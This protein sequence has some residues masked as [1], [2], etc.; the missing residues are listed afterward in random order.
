[1][2]INNFR[3]CLSQALT[4]SAGR[5]SAG[6]RVSAQPQAG[7]R[8][9]GKSI[10]GSSGTGICWRHRERAA[11]SA[12]TGKRFNGDRKA[13]PKPGLA[14]TAA[15]ARGGH[16]SSESRSSHAELPIAWPWPH[17]TGRSHSRLRHCSPA[18][19]WAPSSSPRQSKGRPGWMQGS[20]SQ[21]G[22]G[23][24]EPTQAHRMCPP[25]PSRPVP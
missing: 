9:G 17:S 7:E 22:V 4:G 11:C 16:S 19:P 2:F 21:L 3:I 6:R 24:T 25:A 23:S 10:N 8:W 15:R 5:E 13:R 18:P 20:G 1:M 12:A 14:D